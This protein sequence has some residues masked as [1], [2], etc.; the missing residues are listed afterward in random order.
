MEQHRHQRSRVGIDPVGEVRQGGTGPDADDGVAVTAWNLDA[1]DGRSRLLL[2]LLTLG[3]LRLPAPCRTTT[4]SPEGALRAAAATATPGATE[5]ATAGAATTAGTSRSAATGPTT[6]ATAACWCTR[7][8]HGALTGHHLRRRTGPTT[9]LSSVAASRGV[10]AAA[11][12]TA[13]TGHP[14]RGGERVV[15]GPRGPSAA[16][17]APTGAAATGAAA[18]ARHPLRGGERIVPRTGAGARAGARAGP[19]GRRFWFGPTG[20]VLSCR[21]GRLSRSSAFGASIRV[22][23]S[24]GLGRSSGLRRGLGLCGLLS[25]WFGGRCLRFGRRRRLRFGGCLRLGLRGGG[26]GLALL[27]ALRGLGRGGECL[28]QPA[29]HRGFNR[30]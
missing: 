9:V 13:G 14:L 10:G 4:G 27:G 29:L 23:A 3:P 21:C 16:A 15:T 8:T 20:L 11:T 18:W 7:A 5:T 12:A 6:A 17:G 1:A 30:G 25:C 2:E 22:S 28:S 24:S 26:L 19:R